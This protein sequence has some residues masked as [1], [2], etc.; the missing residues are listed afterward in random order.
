MFQILG[1]GYQGLEFRVSGFGFRTRI[2]KDPTKGSTREFK[3]RAVRVWG[4]S[5]WA[6]DLGFRALGVQGFALKSS[7]PGLRASGGSGFRDWG[8][9]LK[10]WGLGFRV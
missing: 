4:I 7:G 6:S 10:G 5:F 9:G 8:S 2:R 3:V 1:F